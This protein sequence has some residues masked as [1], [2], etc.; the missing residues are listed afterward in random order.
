MKTFH[1]LLTL[2]LGGLF[3][4][5][6]GNKPRTETHS[7]TET[8][9]PV[10]DLQKDYPEQEVFLQDIAD[11]T[12]IPLETTDE[13]VLGV[14]SKII[15]RNDTLIILDLQQ[16]K[17]FF[18]NTE[19]KYLSSFGH[20]GGGKTEYAFPYNLC[21]D[22]DRREILVYD[23]PM[24][25]RI[26]VYDF[27]GNFIRE[28]KLSEEISADGIY[29]YDKDYLL[30]YDVHKLQIPGSGTPSPYPYCFISKTTGEVTRLPLKVEKRKNNSYYYDQGNGTT[31][32]STIQMSPLIMK[33][34]DA[35]I[36]DF[37]LDTIYRY[38]NHV[39]EPIA[40]RQ[41]GEDDM[42]MLSSTLLISDRYCFLNVTHV[43]VN[44]ESHQMESSENKVLMCDRET[45]KVVTVQLAN[46]DI[47]Q[48]KNYTGFDMANMSA[49]D[50][51]FITLYL[52]DVLYSFDEQ[53]LLSGELKAL[54]SRLDP[55]NNPVLMLVKFK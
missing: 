54:M 6:C 44:P 36:T 49:P 10:I 1:V 2:A 29:N 47:P 25:F 48:M 15:C 17:V 34:S 19:G 42:G 45:G 11:V 50:N 41:G 43:Q 4:A 12:Y 9:L 5:S 7:G 16:K 33:G 37:A 3:L 39:L 21:V 24:K 23:T 51:C 22:P 28:L 8:G 13:S 30:A 18:F 38:A 31:M 40:I 27:A 26:V 53:H 46:K 14:I 32:L 52:P 35:V 55:E 20:V